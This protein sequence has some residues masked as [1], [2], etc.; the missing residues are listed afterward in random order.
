M[1]MTQNFSYLKATPPHL[2]CVGRGQVGEMVLKLVKL[3][4]IKTTKKSTSLVKPR[5]PFNSL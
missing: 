5:Y 2:A 1:L 4:K 3:F